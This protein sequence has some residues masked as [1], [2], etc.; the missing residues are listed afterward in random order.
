MRDANVDTIVLGCTHYPLVG[1][2]IES[3][4]AHELTLIHTGDAIAKRLLALAEERGHVNE[5]ELS[6]HLFTTAAIEPQV[7]SMLVKAP[8]TLSRITI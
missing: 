1:E 7:V 2:L 5:G 8:Y 6:L 4:M 3:I